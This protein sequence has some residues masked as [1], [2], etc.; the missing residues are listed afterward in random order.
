ME[1][2]KRPK[3]G[4]VGRAGDEALR[5][6][7]WS[8]PRPSSGACARAASPFWA[9]SNVTVLPHIS[10]PTDRQTA[11]R[12]VADNV[13]RFRRGEQI[14]GVIDADRGYCSR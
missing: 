11:A 3:P 2:D 9:H 14:T 8:A 6:G 7:S 4:G 12:V 13:E 1:E 5:S 10:A